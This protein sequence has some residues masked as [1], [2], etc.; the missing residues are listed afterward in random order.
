[1]LEGRRF[2]YAYTRF[3]HNLIIRIIRFLTEVKFK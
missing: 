1:M 2:G 3:F